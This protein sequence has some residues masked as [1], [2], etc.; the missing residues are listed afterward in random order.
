MFSIQLLPKFKIHE[1]F[2]LL[3]DQGHLSWQSDHPSDRFWGKLNV[4]HRVYQ[5]PE[6]KVFM[7]KTRDCIRQETVRK[8]L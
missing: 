8:E 1:I 5:I 3:A 4:I 7:S 2:E 6:T